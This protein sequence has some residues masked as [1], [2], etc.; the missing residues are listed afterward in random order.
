MSTIKCYGNASKKTSKKYD[1][2]RKYTLLPI[3]SIVAVQRE[4]EDRQT[5]GTKMKKG[6]YNHNN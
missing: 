5:Y 3:G 4:D 2:A 6:D 1:T